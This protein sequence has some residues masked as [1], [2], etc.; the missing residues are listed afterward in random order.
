MQAL[1]K[2]PA[3]LQAG[4]SFTTPAGGEIYVV[5]RTAIVGSKVFAKSRGKDLIATDVAN[6]GKFCLGWFEKGSVIDFSP[7]AALAF[8]LHIKTTSTGGTSKIVGHL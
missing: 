3:T 5:M 4:G 6:G 2:T 8:D 7:A 1:V